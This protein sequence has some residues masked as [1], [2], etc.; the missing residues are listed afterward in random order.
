MRKNNRIYISKG[1]M[2]I[3]LS[4]IGWTLFGAAIYGS[5]C[6]YHAMIS[7][8]TNQQSAIVNRQ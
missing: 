6:L 4:L 7:A 3:V 5:R 1:V 2:L 8:L